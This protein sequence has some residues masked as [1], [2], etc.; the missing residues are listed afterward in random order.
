MNKIFKHS[1]LLLFSALA[2]VLGSCTDEYEYIGATIEGEQVYFSNALSSTVNLDPNASEVKIP[3]NRIQRTGEL[4]VNLNVTTSENCAV[5]VPS[6]VTF[7][8]G[9]SVAYLTVTYNPQT[10]QMGHFDD[11]TVSI[12]DADYTTPYGNSSYAFSIGLSE[13]KSLGSG[14]YHDVIYANFYGAD[15]LTYNVEIQENI[16]KPGI[17]RIVSP[18]GPGTTFYNSYVATGMMGWAGKENTSIVI[19]ATDPNYAYVTGDFYPGTDDG[20]ASQ[21]YGVMHL[22]SVVDDQLRKGSTLD[23]LKAS[24]PELFGTFKDGMITMPS[25]CLYVNFDDTLTPMGYIST[26]GWSMALP[27][28][29]FTDYSSSFTYNGRFTDV[30]GNNYAEGKITLGEDVANAKYIVAMEGDDIQAI[31]DG[32]ADGS[33]EATGITENSDVRVP[34]TESGK[35]VMVIVTFDA[36]GKQRGSSSTSFTFNIGGSGSAN[37]QSVTSGTYDQ[38]YYPNFITDENQNMVGNPF[39]SAKYSTTLYVDGN[40]QSHYKLEPWLTESGS[41]EFTIDDTGIISFDDIDT[42]V[43]S[44]T[45]YGNVFVTNANTIFPDKGP[46]SCYTQDGLFAFGMMYYVVYNGEHGWMG[47]A[48]ELFTPAQ[49]SVP[50]KISSRKSLKQYPAVLRARKVFKPSYDKSINT[51]LFSNKPLKVKR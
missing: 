40:D 3:V 42:G 51:K 24:N 48:T 23:G 49:N 20:M 28:S 7:A 41:L 16:L 38:N 43:D 31:I 21:G 36:E 10:I 27:G 26:A 6:S 13:W 47:G 18:Y 35:Y 15:A 9:D 5:S 34:I 25:T 19:D 2:L 22:F 50:F 11:V 44:Q 14:L 33:V 37:W 17:Y 39:G 30:A 45:Q 1:M 12:A 4:T 8:D 32:I 29:E 46:F